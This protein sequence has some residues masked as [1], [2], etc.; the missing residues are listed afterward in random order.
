MFG[1]KPVLEKKSAFGRWRN[2]KSKT[3]L[4][5]ALNYAS[6]VVIFPITSS[7]DKRGPHIYEARP[8]GVGAYYPCSGSFEISYQGLGKFKFK[9]SKQKPD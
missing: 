6:G 7:Q 5:G 8:K 3:T 1:L 2:Y 9:V 4:T